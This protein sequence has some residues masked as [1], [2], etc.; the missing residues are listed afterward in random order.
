MGKIERDLGKIEKLGGN[1]QRERFGEREK[2]GK[3]Q[4]ETFGIFFLL[5]EIWGK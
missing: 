1:T 2:L 4:G 3:V 5:R